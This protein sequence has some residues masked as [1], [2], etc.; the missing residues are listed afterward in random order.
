L[1]LI[2]LKIDCK[3]L[4]TDKPKQHVF[5]IQCLGSDNSL[6]ERVFAANSSLERDEWINSIQNV[7]MT[8]N[9][10]FLVDISGK[11]GNK[12]VSSLC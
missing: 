3:I 2:V 6:V 7:S 11:C 12:I 5:I 8:L 1:L 10:Q 4:T 9:G